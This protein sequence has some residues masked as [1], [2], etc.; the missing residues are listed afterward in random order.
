MG[1]RDGDDKETDTTD[2]QLDYWYTKK[3]EVHKVFI[4]FNVPLK[5][6]ILKKINR[7]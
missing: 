1:A 6:P 3:K 5:L 7:K 2:L 4:I